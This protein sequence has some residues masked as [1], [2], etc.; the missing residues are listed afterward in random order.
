MAVIIKCD[1]CDVDV[2][3]TEETKGFGAM[4]IIMKQY[5]FTKK[6]KIGEQGLVKKDFDICSDCCDKMSKFIEDSKKEILKK[7]ETT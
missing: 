3:K 4:S 5:T 6:G 1:I 2:D 7:V